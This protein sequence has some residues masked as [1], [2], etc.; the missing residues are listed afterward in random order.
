[1]MGSMCRS[2]FFALLA[3]A[4]TLSAADLDIGSAAHYTENRGRNEAGLGPFYQVVVTATVVPS[5]F[6]TLVVAE[7]AKVREAML[8]FA[9][10]LTSTP[11][12]SPGSC[13][14]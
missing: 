3:W 9:T 10:T 6:P 7:Q 4:T 14:T 12:L 8:L 11:A 2:T 1:M 13:P 5:D